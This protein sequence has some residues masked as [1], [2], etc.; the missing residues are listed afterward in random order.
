MSRLWSRFGIR[1][2]SVVLL[3]VGVVGGV[4]LGRDREFQQQGI[5]AQLAVQADLAEQQLLKDRHSEHSVA[6][7][8]QREAEAEA[9][10]KAA[11]AAKAAAERAQKAKVAVSRKKEREKA[12]ED[13][14][15]AKP[16]AGPIPKSCNQYTVNRKNACPEHNNTGY[17]IDQIP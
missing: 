11:G 4:Y 3:L 2:I 5:E 7:A 8:P 9:A 13:H 16:Y 15:A 1:A 10:A 17:V 14:A 12:A 6:V